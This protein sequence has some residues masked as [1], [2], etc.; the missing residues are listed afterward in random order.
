MMQRE[1]EAPGNPTRTDPTTPAI[2]ANRTAPSEPV[3]CPRV[4]CPR[5]VPHSVISPARA[6]FSTYPQLF[7]NIDRSCSWHERNTTSVPEHLRRP[8]TRRARFGTAKSAV[9][10]SLSADC[11]FTTDRSGTQHRNRCVECSARNASGWADRPIAGRSAPH[12]PAVQS[13]SRTAS[14]LSDVQDCIGSIDDRLVERI[15]V[16]RRRR[17][18]RLD[19]RIDRIGRSEPPRRCP[20]RTRF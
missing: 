8:D 3:G 5:A 1:A 16:L 7:H 12:P 20:V 18:G 17:I 14:S 19:G 13:L 6:L 9:A 11:R 4:P 2:L 15:V 10:T